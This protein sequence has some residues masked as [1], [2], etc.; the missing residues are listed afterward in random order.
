[1]NEKLLRLSLYYVLYTPSIF[2]I[3]TELQSKYDK[4]LHP[5]VSGENIFA[6]NMQY[7]RGFS[8][9]KKCVSWFR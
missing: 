8:R 6:P 5:L 2:V 3:D 4:I 7:L 9:D 1:M